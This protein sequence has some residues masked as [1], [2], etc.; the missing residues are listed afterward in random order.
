MFRFRP[1]KQFLFSDELGEYVSYGIHV[2][3]LTPAGCAEAGFFSDISCDPGFVELLARRCT[4][5]QLDPLH[6][7]DIVADA[8]S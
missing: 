6:L 8:L 7:P 2:F 3:L 5:E 4:R 1:V